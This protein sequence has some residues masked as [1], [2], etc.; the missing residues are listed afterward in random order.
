MPNTHLKIA[1]A[2]VEI[3]NRHGDESD[4]TATELAELV[5]TTP[6]LVGAAMRNPTVWSVFERAGYQLDVSGDG[7]ISFRRIED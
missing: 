1:R 6:L 5:N 7:L 4:F 2:T 3:L